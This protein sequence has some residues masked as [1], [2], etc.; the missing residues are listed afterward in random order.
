MLSD[1]QLRRQ[2]SLSARRAATP[3]TAFGRRLLC[4][5]AAMALAASNN[6]AGAHRG[7]DDFRFKRYSLEEGLSQG[8]VF[9]IEQDRRGFL[10]IGTQDGLNRFDGNTFTVFNHIP[11]D[12]TSLSCNRVT[13][14]A[15]DDYGNLWV[16]T[17]HGLNVM[18][19]GEETFTRY[20][21][22]PSS[23]AGTGVDNIKCL[24]ADSRGFIWIGTDCGIDRFDP[25]EGVF[26]H[27]GHGPAD[28]GS[29]SDDRAYAFC[30]T[31]DQTL[32]IGTECG[33]NR[34][35]R[36]ADRF[37]RYVPA[38]ASDDKAVNAVRAIARGP[39]GKLYLG[40]GRGVSA[41]DIASEAFSQ[42]NLRDGGTAA[43]SSVAE[44]PF[45]TD[46]IVDNTG[47]IWAGTFDGL[48]VLSPESGTAVRL[49]NH[50]GDAGSLSLDAVI[51][52]FQDNCDVVWVGTNGYGLN[53]WSPYLSKFGHYSY[54]EDGTEGLSF[55]SV[56]AI[57][58]DPSGAVWVGGYG[59]GL[60]RRDPIT[61][62]FTRSRTVPMGTAYAILGDPDEPEQVLWV[63]SQGSGLLRY[64]VARDEF[65][66]CVPRAAGGKDL[67][68]D[69]VFSL[70]ADDSGRLWIGTEK[71]IDILDRSTGELSHLDCCPRGTYIRAIVKDCGG[72]VWVASS[73]GLGRL[74]PGAEGFAMYTHDPEDPA[75]LATDDVICVLEDSR[76][77][78]WAGTNGGGLN[79]LD[80]SKGTFRHYLASDGLP[81]NVVYGVL[82]D[83]HGHLWLSTNSGIS[84]FDPLTESFHNFAVDDGLQSLEFNTN[85]YHKGASGKLYFGGTLGVNIIEP[86]NLVGD[87]HT[88]RVVL[89]RLSILNKPVPA[90]GE[91]DGR[92][93]LSKSISETARLELTHKDDVISFELA[94]LNLA[95]PS[96][97]Q[98]AYKLEGFDD[99]WI[100]IGNR[101]HISFTD[102]NPGEYTLLVKAANSDGVWNETPTALTI[103]I[104][105]PIWQTWWLRCLAVVA[106]GALILAAHKARTRS[107]RR[108]GDELN[109]S[110][111]FL[112]S[113]INALDDPV[114]VKDEKHR[115]VVLNDKACEMLGR[116]RKDLLGK[117]NY[118]VFSKEHADQFCRED[119]E[120]FASGGT[121]VDEETVNWQGQT[122]IVSTKK[123]KF[124]QGET[125]KRYLASAVRDITHL[126]Q[127]ESALEERLRFESVVSMISAQ[128]IN[129]PVTDID[130]VIESGLK[131]IGEFFGADRVVIRL[132]K[133][134]RDL[135]SKVYAWRADG[136][137]RSLVKDDF[138][139][140]FPNLA[141]E[142]RSER[143]VVFDS[144]GDF[145]SSWG[146]ERDHMDAIGIRSGVVVPLSVGGAVLGSISVLMVGSERNWAEST[147]PRVRI[148]GEIMANALN[149]KRADEALKQSQQKYWSIL[150][151]IGIGIALFSKDVE[152][153]EINKKM[154]EWLPDL[155]DRDIPFCCRLTE[156]APYEHNC[157]D[158]PLS[159]TLRD[160]RVHEATST[161]SKA[162]GAA[163]FRVVASPIRNSLE[164]VVA[165]IVIVED[166]TEKQRLEDQLRH[167]Q[168]M[169]AIG[170][171]AGGIAH[172]FNNILY[173]LLGYANLAKRDVLRDSDVHDY[174]TQIERAGRRAAELVEQ[175]LAFS[176]RA[177]SDMR[178]VELQSIVHEALTLLR[179]SLPTTVEITHD[180]A[181]DCGPVLANPTQIH[182]V[183][184][185]LCTNASQA[186]PNRKGALH[187][188]LEQIQNDSFLAE[189]GR[190]HGHAHYARLIVR[191]NGIG[192]DPQILKRVFE[193]YFTTKGQGEGSGLGL[194]MVHGIVKSHGGVINI[195][196]EPGCGTSFTIYLPVCGV[197]A[198]DSDGAGVAEDVAS[199]SARILF[200]DD[201]S[202]IADMSE[203][204]LRK[205][206][207]QVD[208]FTDSVEAV[209]A[210]RARPQ[211]YDL[212]LTDVT[213]PKLTGL[214]LAD[215][216]RAARDD[217]PIILCTGYSDSLDQESLD[218]LRV[219][220]CIWKPVEFD[221]LGK[222]IQEAIASSE[223]TKV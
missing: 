170:T 209:E 151:N 103:A 197:G 182:Q 119:E 127:Y 111:D 115:W 208:V 181:A 203:R 66:K 30:E 32:W 7:G 139:A 55:K 129:P 57:Y 98:F 109:R 46:M 85:A 9:A 33:L 69:H 193:P 54:H 76:G 117:T 179:G 221:E 108:R 146:P 167:S 70:S 4:A 73:G 161:L 178:P 172:D 112:N 47:R 88:P 176:R 74:D 1:N 92:R 214:E 2:R 154:R 152:V 60:N 56:R 166:V 132:M 213:M 156:S 210:F 140:A 36:H 184:M 62:K 169:E 148:L 204:I 20:L 113:I 185:N 40:T 188:G 142:L 192:M 18:A 68:G 164:E 84:C 205:L 116:P 17:G 128:L 96:R 136:F 162:D 216:I 201:E 3:R 25:R 59:G 100:D 27:Y 133:G 187:L 67:A 37:Y 131:E 39:S 200:V 22:E 168:K 126:K 89:T 21:H 215:E 63:G 202:I 219:F 190:K 149:R 137:N 90:S 189:H 145:P 174:L 198:H 105:P 134:E 75:S 138:E 99:H 104:S 29:I 158:C 101:R 160:G 114:F 220:R 15:A 51:S 183:L 43:S 10:W 11:F 163:S 24:H 48:F 42:V 118:D 77:T 28:T 194:A 124:T 175:I 217:I 35:D 72:T 23:H 206:G 95:A 141:E 186:M 12:T 86:D 223:P 147:T 78:M 13:S 191:D 125:G 195:D 79:K 110:K 177:D 120:A 64:D 91:L 171:L 94:G 97:N 180:I 8:S 83:R 123:S 106:F 207:H 49:I 50:S 26:T 157:P 31:D 81:N 143:E 93:L 65:K 121:I 159:Q 222:L 155:G 218:E 80:R 61:G 144:L 45:V 6:P 122:R 102:L 107:Y 196:S 5:L 52:L 211:D 71:G 41:F 130:T 44:G 153:L 135:P 58:E 150:E 87:P 199:R 53:A 34:Y 173:A 38:P 82:E 14:L 16:G 212:V 19:P 165:A